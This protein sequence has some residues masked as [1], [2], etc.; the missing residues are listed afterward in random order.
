MKRTVVFS[1]LFILL[2][3][4]LMSGAGSEVGS[5]GV[6]AQVKKQEPG[7][8]ATPAT[9]ARLPAATGRVEYPGRGVRSQTWG[10]FHTAGR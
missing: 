4:L 9:Q 6:Q 7:L 8:P 5:L 2:V 10:L 1:A 3:S